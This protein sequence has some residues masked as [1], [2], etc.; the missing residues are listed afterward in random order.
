[1]DHHVSYANTDHELSWSLHDHSLMCTQSVCST[2]A[3][4]LHF[5]SSRIDCS[6]ALREGASNHCCMSMAHNIVDKFTYEVAR[7][8]L[9]QPKLP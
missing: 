9:S 8:H 3:A 1:M 7:C 4:Y 5:I 2:L 6:S